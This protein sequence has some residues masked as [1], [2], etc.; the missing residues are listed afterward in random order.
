MPSTFPEAGAQRRP[1]LATAME[2]LR[3]RWGWFLALG[4]LSIAFGPLALAMV[5][6][7]TFTAVYINAI[8][9]ILAAASE[10]TVGFG[11]QGWGRSSLLV[12]GGLLF[13]VA[14]STSWP[15]PSPW[16]VPVLPP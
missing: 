11:S 15:V 2:R 10:V 12:L 4:I 7:A 3:D 16:R 8:F 5:F 1:T 6:A 9:M 13:W 14:C